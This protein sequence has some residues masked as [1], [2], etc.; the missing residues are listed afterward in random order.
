[1]S[2]S[3]RREPTFGTLSALSPDPAETVSAAA[4]R[5]PPAH[6]PGAR[7]TVVIN[8]LKLHAGDNV[9]KYAE[10]SANGLS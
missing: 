2:V 7:M 6:A 10:E 8:S 1:M 4:A 3:S 5:T 9:A